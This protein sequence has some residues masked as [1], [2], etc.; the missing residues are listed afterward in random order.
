MITEQLLTEPGM[1]E[2][3]WD[4]AHATVGRVAHGQPQPVINSAGAELE[5]FLCKP[6]G[7]L[8]SNKEKR[9]LLDQIN[10][11]ANAGVE[12]GAA[13]IELSPPPVPLKLAGF[14]GW[15]A[16][17][18][19]KQ[20]I[21]VETAS[22]KGFLVGRHGTVPWL[23]FGQ[24]ERTVDEIKYLQVP[25]FHD[26]HRSPL[27]P[28]NIGSVTLHSAAAV[29][30]LSSFQFTIEAANLDDGLDKLNR[31]YML[32]PLAVALSANARVIDEQDSGWADT[33][34]EV[35]RQTHDVRTPQERQFDRSLRVGLPDDY[36]LNIDQYFS[37]IASRPFILDKPNAALDIGTGLFWRDARLKFFRNTPT[38]ITC[39]VEFRPISIQ[40][41]VEE[42]IAMAAFMIGRLIWSQQYQEPL[43]KMPQVRT[44]KKAA[45]KKGFAANFATGENHLK[46][47][48]LVLQRD[49]KRAEQGLKEAGLMDTTAQ[50]GLR[51]LEERLLRRQTPG[52]RLIS[53][54][55]P[56]LI[57]AVSIVS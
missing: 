19:E 21:L 17:L 39:G 57:R 26:V 35:W 1:V 37:D 3:F 42:D 8:I 40:P 51:M 47:A 53:L 4:Q 11:S 12:L 45:E 5:Y 13:A 52:E 18:K 38:N 44:N 2:A 29:G 31:L 16:Q 49:L 14:K 25:D 41:T 7:T 36:Y 32:S 48:L 28:M 23:G 27:S 15:L 24:I 55:R 43:L 30:L 34:M 10:G 33:R 22:Q 20:T 46:P 56:E 9:G 54:T 6:D 50:D